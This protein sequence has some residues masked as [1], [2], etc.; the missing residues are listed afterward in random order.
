MNPLFWLWKQIFED[1]DDP[2]DPDQLVELCAPSGEPLPGLWQGI[3]KSEGILSVAKSDRPPF[4]FGTPSITI[5]VQYK[6]YD[7]ARELLDLEAGA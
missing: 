5:Q 4:G 3:L 7:R 1:N 6:D 2:P